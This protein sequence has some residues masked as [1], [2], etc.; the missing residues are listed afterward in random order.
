MA[1]IGAEF[2]GP[3]SSAPKFINE[4][5]S[6]IGEIAATGQTNTEYKGSAW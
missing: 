5:R 6:R 4:L 1:M 2:T 3:D